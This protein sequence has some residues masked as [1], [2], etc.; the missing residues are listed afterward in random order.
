MRVTFTAR[1]CVGITRSRASS[2]TDTV[3]WSL[4]FTQ[5]IVALNA[6]SFQN[7]LSS[8]VT[9]VTAWK[10]EVSVMQSLLAG[11]EWKRFLMHGCE[12]QKRFCVLLQL[13]GFGFELRGFPCG[14][15]KVTEKVLSNWELASP[16]RA[17]LRDYSVWACWMWKTQPTFHN[18]CTAEA[19]QESV[20]EVQ[21]SS[22]GADFLLQLFP[23]WAWNCVSSARHQTGKLLSNKKPHQ[24]CVPCGLTTQICWMLQDFFIFPE[25]LVTQRSWKNKPSPEAMKQP[26]LCVVKNLE[27]LQPQNDASGKFSAVTCPPFVCGFFQTLMQDFGLERRPQIHIWHNFDTEHWLENLTLKIVCLAMTILIFTQTFPR[28]HHL[29]NI[30]L[31]SQ[32]GS[33]FFHGFPCVCHCLFLHLENTK[34][35]GF[36]FHFP[37]LSHWATKSSLCT[38]AWDWQQENHNVQLKAKAEGA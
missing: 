23:S 6:E 32:C 11:F 24:R 17:S 34:L 38:K 28:W 10:E 12:T 31:A 7:N 25:M 18:S 3:L 16:T 33:N 4:P 21:A 8:L 36:S 26:Q 14:E 22:A 27:K 15:C 20:S 37:C 35:A 1:A 5:C 2:T 30:L 29:R 9:V 19:V 13:C